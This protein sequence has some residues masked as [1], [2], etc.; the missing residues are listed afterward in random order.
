MLYSASQYGES[1]RIHSPESATEWMLKLIIWEFFCTLTWNSGARS[2]V[3]GRLT[4]PVGCAIGRVRSGQGVADPLGH[5]TFVVRWERGGI[6]GLP[7]CHILIS[8]LPERS[9]PRVLH[10]EAR[11]GI[12]RMGSR[13]F[14]CMILTRRAT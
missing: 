2:C 8:R 7:L 1:S 12:D 5:L 11:T 6:G 4:R 10:R 3:K 9:L 14:V 13:R